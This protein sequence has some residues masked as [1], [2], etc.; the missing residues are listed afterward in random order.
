MVVVLVPEVEQALVEALARAADPDQEA[1]LALEEA[2]DGVAVQVQVVTVVEEK[3]AF[4]ISRH[5]I[6]AG[7]N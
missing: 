7:L 1:V 4:P 6:N 3:V 5:V 2:P